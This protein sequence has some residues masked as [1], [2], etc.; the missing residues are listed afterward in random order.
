MWEADSQPDNNG[1]NSHL[2]V[3]AALNDLVMPDEQDTVL[4]RPFRPHQMESP[5]RTAWPRRRP[6]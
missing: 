4:R 5:E 1:H 3:D 6:W 2:R